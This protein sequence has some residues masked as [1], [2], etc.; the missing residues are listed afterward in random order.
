MDRDLTTLIRD[1]PDF[2]IAGILFRDIT[3]LLKDGEAF[4]YARTRASRARCME[5]SRSRSAGSCAGW[6]GAGAPGAGRDAG[7]ATTSNSLITTG[8]RLLQ[9]RCR[10]RSPD[11]P[12]TVGCRG[13]S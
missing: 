1:I 7:S 2:P 4:Q 10:G 3:T 8:I 5:S 9:A 13:R 12:S 11:R 6:L